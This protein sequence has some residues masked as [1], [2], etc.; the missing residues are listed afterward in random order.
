M[1]VLGVLLALALVPPL[2]G[3]TGGRPAA[4]VARR[5]PPA[6]ATV[7]LTGFALTVSLATGMMLCLAAFLGTVELFPFA[8]PSDWSAGTLRAR[9]PVPS[10]AGL[11]AGTLAVGLL[12]RAG[13]H[14]VRVVAGARR[15]S[16]AV[17]VLPAVGELAV[18]DDPAAHAYAVAGRHRRVVVSTGMLRSLTGPQRRALLAHEHAHL[19]HHHHRYTRLAWLAAAANPLLTP[20]ARAVDQ[21]AE[22]WADAVAVRAVGDPATVAHALGR[23]ALAGPPSSHG[24]GAA[25]HDVVDRI[26]DLLEPPRRQASAGLLLGAAAVVCWASTAAVLFHTY[27]VIEFAETVVR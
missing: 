9:I 8:H 15:A 10:A 23:A 14:L 18:V 20:V 21:A 24:L 19:R 17:A 4:R 12:G 13:L 6:A 25:G 2:V 11:A 16:A 3:A 1:I 5:V 7:L 26:R 22:R 27:N